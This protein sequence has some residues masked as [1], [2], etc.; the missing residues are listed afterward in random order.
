MTIT[1]RRRRAPWLIGG[2]AVAV[3][4]VVAALILIPRPGASADASHEVVDVE[5]V[6]V[7][8]GDLIERVRVKGT[9]AFA[10]THELGTTLGG[11]VTAVTDAGATVGQGGELFRIDDQPVLLFLGSLP[12]WRALSLG[13]EDGR[14]VLQ[15][16]QNLAALGFFEREPDEEFAQSTATAIEKWQKS[17]GLEKTGA[18]EPGR[19][20]FGA[21]PVRIAE[22]KAAIGDAAGPAIVSVSDTEKRVSGFIAPNLKEV[23]AVGSAVSVMLPDGTAVPGTITTVGAPVE[24]DDGMGGKSLKLPITIS[25]D[26]PAQADAFSDVSVSLTLALTKSADALLVPVLA[27]L[28]QPGGGFAVETLKG[29]N[30]TI[31]PVEL[32]AFADGMVEIVSGKLVEGAAVVV[33]Q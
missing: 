1:M 4:A 14:D 33:G 20:V 12:M 27:L 3:A 29:T 9:L 17:L 19:I 24:K 15:L 10:G 28:A 2:A 26:D 31:V 23:A 6:N 25:L 21:A 18:I 8:R 11:T 22:R 5:T 32:G 7:S 16:E 30:S 13:V